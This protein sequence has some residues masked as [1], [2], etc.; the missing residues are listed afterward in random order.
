MKRHSL[1]YTQCKVLACIQLF[2]SIRFS[3]GLDIFV[4]GNIYRY[5]D[6]THM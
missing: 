3:F 4:F 2:N 1:N 6:N 5:N